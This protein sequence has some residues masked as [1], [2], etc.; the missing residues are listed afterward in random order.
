[1][2]YKINLIG[3]EKLEVIVPSLASPQDF[4]GVI[5]GKAILS[6]PLKE[7]LGYGT[8]DMRCNN[9]CKNHSYLPQVRGPAC[10]CIGVLCS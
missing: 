5:L 4:P 10:E 6:L 1:M 7:E 2:R 3:E 8:R 9:F